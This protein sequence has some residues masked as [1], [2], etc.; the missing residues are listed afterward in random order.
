MQTQPQFWR[1]TAPIVGVFFG[2]IFILIC[3]K[4]YS[5]TELLKFIGSLL[6]PFGPTHWPKL[7][8]EVMRKEQKYDLDRFTVPSIQPT[9]PNTPT[10]ND[11]SSGSSLLASTNPPSAQTHAPNGGASLPFVEKRDR[12]RNWLGRL[13][14]KRGRRNS[15][16]Q[17]PVP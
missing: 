11:P 9:D 4:K 1:Y 3:F 7:R 10:T 2:M 6:N 16:T 8:T 15:N 12:K 14:D 13:F 5:P 17:G